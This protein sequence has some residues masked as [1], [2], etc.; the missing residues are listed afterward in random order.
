MQQAMN[1][2]YQT[3]IMTA[4]PEELTL[5]LYNGCI[6]FLKQTEASMNNKNFSEKSTFV[7]KALDILDEL[8]VTLDMKY[9]IS[10]QLLSLYEYFKERLTYASIHMNTDVLREVITMMEELRDTWQEA[11]KLV[12]Q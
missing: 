1:R 5:M 4:T 10:S 6:R 2:Y 8:Q 12:K 7:S 11:I 3:Q 9:E